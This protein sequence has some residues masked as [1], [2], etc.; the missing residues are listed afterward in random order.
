M[1]R[2]WP[3]RDPVWGCAPCRRGA[4]ERGRQIRSSGTW[5]GSMGAECRSCRKTWRRGGLAVLKKSHESGFRVPGIR[6][7]PCRSLALEGLAGQGCC[8]SER[9]PEFLAHLVKA[10]AGPGDKKD[11]CRRTQNDCAHL[12]FLGKK[13]LYRSRVRLHQGSAGG[14]GFLNSSGFMN[15][16]WA[17]S[18]AP[19][20]HSW[21]Q[22]VP[23]GWKA[24][25]RAGIL[26]SGL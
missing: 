10:V 5:P 15:G 26:Q 17:R 1:G 20:A 14:W 8:N 19:A 11:V 2:R 23:G 18:L 6:F 9:F 22:R 24:Q 3:G 7:S 13:S 12:S 21:L 16:G 25:D 4:F